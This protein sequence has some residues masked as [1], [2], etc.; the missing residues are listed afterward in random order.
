MACF[1]LLLLCITTV[2]KPSDLRRAVS[3]LLSR[4]TEM[5]VALLPYISEQCTADTVL[6]NFKLW[7]SLIRIIDTD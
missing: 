5:G 6:F 1:Y 2:D 3:V 7:C 4:Q